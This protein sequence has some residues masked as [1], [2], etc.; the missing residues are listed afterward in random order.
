MSCA[1]H[2]VAAAY[3]PD[4]AGRAPAPRTAPVTVTLKAAPPPIRV[5][6]TER[7]I[8]RAPS[9]LPRSEPAATVASIEESHDPRQ[10]EPP[11]VVAEAEPVVAALMLPSAA[12]AAAPSVAVDAGSKVEPPRFDVAYLQNPPPAYPSIARRLRL[13]GTVVL[14]VLVDASGHA[15]ELRIDR[16]SGAA[17]LDEAA[18]GAIRLWRFV[19]G[20]QGPEAIARWVDVPVRFRLQD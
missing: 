18:L 6:A 13:E 15:E 14:R 1:V 4:I 17:I 9:P 8:R 19:P 3:L 7:V 10:P 12:A 5:A 20:R 16:T 2:A 11:S